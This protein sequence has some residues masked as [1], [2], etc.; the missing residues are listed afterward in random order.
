VHDVR[1]VDRLAQLV[2]HLP[3]VVR[4]Q[5]EQGQD[6][7]FAT[8]ARSDVQGSAR[9]RLHHLG[10]SPQG[11]IAGLMAVAVV[12]GFE[13]VNVDQ[14]Q[15]QLSA[16]AKRLLPH[17]REIIVER[18]TIFQPRKPIPCNQLAHQPAFEKRRAQLPLYTSV[19]E[20]SHGTRD[21]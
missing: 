1:V 14:K 21:C 2:S 4:T 20:R 10:H 13:V 17:P 6:E 19:Y 12:V 7:L 16:I 3:D 5:I 18:P 9:K 8:V 11:L 15:C